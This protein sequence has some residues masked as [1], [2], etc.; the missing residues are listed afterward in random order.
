[1]SIRDTWVDSEVVTSGDN[2]YH[3]GLDVILPVSKNSERLYPEP[4]TT[5]DPGIERSNLLTATWEIEDLPWF[6]RV[7][8]ASNVHAWDQGLDHRDSDFDKW[9]GT[10]EPSSLADELKTYHTNRIGGIPKP[11]DFEFKTF[12]VSELRRAAG[13]RHESPNLLA[14]IHDK[15]ELYR[16]G[17]GDLQAARDMLGD[18]PLS[19][20]MLDIL[21]NG[22][23][24]E[25][26]DDF[27]RNEGS[28]KDLSP[29]YTES[30]ESRNKVHHG[31]VEDYELGRVLVIPWEDL[32]EEEKKLFHVS[33]VTL[34][35]KPGAYL[36]RTCANFSS[37]TR[38]VPSLNESIDIDRSQRRYPKVR[39]PTIRT[40][41][42]MLVAKREATPPGEALHIALCDVSSAYKTLS[43]DAESACLQSIFLL[44][45]ADQP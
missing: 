40:V 1:M 7:V 5:F 27:Q 20:C 26:H 23:H 28:N 25:M 2:V 4:I 45:D 6:D 44:V 17:H 24:L 42:D 19:P 21:A 35:P 39:L 16:R 14:W 38:R 29:L 13:Q 8:E 31:F 12:H 34:A 10:I 33:K 32:T 22:V 15:C 36:G 11:V 30:A 18:H 41:A 9:V 37:R 3:N 43:M